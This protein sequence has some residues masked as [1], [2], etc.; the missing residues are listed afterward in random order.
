MPEKV[1][2]TSAH[3]EKS[4]VSPVSGKRKD[5]EVVRFPGC[6]DS[7]RRAGMR[8]GRSPVGLDFANTSGMSKFELCMKK[9]PTVK[10]HLTDWLQ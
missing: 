9:S 5:K 1:F 6:D 4:E 10:E 2:W 3:A 7:H 8:A